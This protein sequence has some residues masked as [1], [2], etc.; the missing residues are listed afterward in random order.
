M[1]ATIPAKLRLNSRRPGEI[2][3]E[4]DDQHQTPTSKLQGNSQ[5]QAPNLGVR[6]SV[7]HLELGVSREAGAGNLEHLNAIPLPPI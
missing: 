4:A 7:W 2:L 1:L 6:W 5:H 3:S